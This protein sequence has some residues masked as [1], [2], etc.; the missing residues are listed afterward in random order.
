MA[1]GTLPRSA[2]LRVIGDMISRFGK[3]YGPIRVLSR[4]ERSVERVAHTK[5][6]SDHARLRI[7]VDNRL[8]ISHES[9]VY[10]S[11]VDLRA[12]S[13]YWSVSFSAH[14]LARLRV[15]P[16]RSSRPDTL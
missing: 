15:S 14:S 8:L 5:T 1:V 13:A 11:S 16:D 3:S 7:K 12:M 4:V 10:R 2:R 6:L 9:V